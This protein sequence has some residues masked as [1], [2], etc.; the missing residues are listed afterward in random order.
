MLEGIIYA[1]AQSIETKGSQLKTPTRGSHLDWPTL[2]EDAKLS[3]Y[4]QLLEN[5]LK[6]SSERITR[7][8]FA[9]TISC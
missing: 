4:G 7:E 8:P 9:I 2:K 5:L 6:R 3:L 1:F